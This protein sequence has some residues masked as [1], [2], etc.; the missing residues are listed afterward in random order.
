MKP[1][2]GSDEKGIRH[3]VCLLDE[4]HFTTSSTQ[5]NDAFTEKRM[6]SRRL[7]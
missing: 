1:A 7:P 2:T 6:G 5:G 4:S 3:V